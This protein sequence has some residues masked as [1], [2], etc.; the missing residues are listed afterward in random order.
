LTNV[1]EHPN[2]KYYDG[3][4]IEET[5]MLTKNFKAVSGLLLVTGVAMGLAGCAS[6]TS[7][8]VASAAAN[9]QV[10]TTP[11][12]AMSSCRYVGQVLSQNV[13]GSPQHPLTLDPGEINVIKN[14]AAQLGANV[15]VVSPYNT[16]SATVN[17]RNTHNVLADAYSC[18]T[19]Y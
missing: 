4:S 13:T 5:A 12:P 17:G 14:A 10:T 1:K 2:C 18:A 16:T 8:P 6:S 3:F 9:I 15:V 19:L 7:V 11:P